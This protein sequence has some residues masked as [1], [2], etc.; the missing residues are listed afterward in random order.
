MIDWT[1]QRLAVDNEAPTYYLI[2]RTLVY[3]VESQIS[4]VLD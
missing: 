4:L 3:K 1:N 2:T